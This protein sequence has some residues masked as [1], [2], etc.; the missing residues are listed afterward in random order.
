M[1][2]LA[3]HL[4]GLF[5]A[6][7][8][9]GRRI[10]FPTTKAQAM[11][12]YLLVEEALQPGISHQRGK[13]MT[14][15]WPDITPESAQTNLRQTLYRLR[16]TLP[17]IEV[18]PGQIEQ[19]IISDRLSVKVNT[20]V[21]YRLD[22]VEFERALQEA[23]EGSE[24]R[25]LASLTKATDFYRGPFLADVS[26]PDS[27][28]FEN[29]ARQIREELR[30]IALEALHQLG[31]EALANEDWHQVQTA[32]RRQIVLDEL[33]EAAYRQLML[34]QAKAGQRNK[35]LAE[36]AT[37]TQ[38]LAEELGVE[39]MS[40]TTRLAAAIRKGSVE[41]EARPAINQKATLESDTVGRQAE[42][43]L[44]DKVDRFWVTG[45]L[46]QSLLGGPRLELRMETMPAALATPWEMVVGQP[47]QTK[48]LLPA[49]ISINQVFESSG[50]ALL[51]LGGPGAGKTTTL[52][53]LARGKVAEAKANSA[54]P[55]PVVFNLSSWADKRLPI[56]EWLVEELNIKYLIPI[57][58]GRDWVEAGRLL[59]LLDGLDEVRAESQAAC[60]VAIN[61]FRQDY[62][63][64][65]LAVGSRSG[66]YGDLPEKLLLGQAI[67]LLPLDSIQ[68][69]HYWQ[70]NVGHQS[71]LAEI[72]DRD[73]QLAHLAQSPLMLHIMTLT[74]RD[75][76]DTSAS[77]DTAV[78]SR[79]QLL[80][81]YVRHMFQRR[82]KRGDFPPAQTM[83]YL[84]WLA[85][86]LFEQDQTIFLLEQLQPS[87]LQLASS[88]WIYALTTRVIVSMLI[89]LGY[90]I[91]IIQLEIGA[92]TLPA[93]VASLLTS[94]LIGLL[95]GS[96]D[97]YRFQQQLVTGK[98]SVGRIHIGVMLVRLIVVGLLTFLITAVIFSA[99]GFN[100]E[101]T[102][103]V[104]YVYAFIY[105]LL[106]GVR[107]RKR[108]VGGDIRPVETV[109]WSWQGALVGSIPGL[110][111]GAVLGLLDQ[112]VTG[113][114]RQIS[115]ILFFAVLGS[116]F[117]GLVGGLRRGAVASDDRP[118]NGLYLSL[119][120]GLR[121][122]LLF[123]LVAAV[124]FVMIFSLDPLNAPYLGIALQFALRLAFALG[125]LALLWYG[126][127][128]VLNHVV[129]Q[130]LLHIE[131]SIPFQYTDFLNHA[132]DLIF[133][134]RVG[135][136]YIFVHQL[137][138]NYFAQ[139]KGD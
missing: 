8:V 129:L 43:I 70:E 39:P 88:R 17:P 138:H 40:E 119:R 107:G 55:L 71:A 111:A 86:S 76:K 121:V 26:V 20:A 117:T 80:D 81:A 47:E 61:D 38:L 24:E 97:G 44:L 100:S 102:A 49:D 13:L 105:A 85:R 63:L 78:A 18:E 12:A 96:F 114:T 59:L 108:S 58:I 125:L 14:L 98:K 91:G 89:A 112:Y 103:S 9:D 23:G 37:L 77:L 90:L 3:F 46:Q 32:A 66:D 122:G 1:S 45:V 30:R 28:H 110:I 41:P 35:A 31:E 11:L 68:V 128:E 131:G 15:L 135:G 73:S 48:Q 82:G 106:F 134:R 133:L 6:K 136:G 4:F 57:K 21:P 5:E 16:K 69:E 34:A 127:I 56:P 92:I 109:I 95:L 74:F 25:R 94:L 83:D 87:W 72:F 101:Q 51:I 54:A 27:E 33:N 22:V 65:P 118:N 19:L 29:W 42:K 10:N 53:E 36:Y 84:G 130:I 67:Q 7:D 52:L 123:G 126:G 75:E 64:V 79:Q 50:Q 120:Y 137:L 99:F 104:A 139:I 113:T 60:V 2:S 132:V 124:T 93:G 62:G 115:V 116:L